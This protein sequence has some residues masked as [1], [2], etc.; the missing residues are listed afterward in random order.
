M[1]ALLGASSARYWLPDHC[2]GK[3]SEAEAAL[4]QRE[5]YDCLAMS[6]TGARLE[7]APL[8]LYVNCFCP[9]IVRYHYCRFFLSPKPKPL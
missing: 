8:M 4:S 9:Q 3:D 5:C 6:T 2:V 7:G 1:H